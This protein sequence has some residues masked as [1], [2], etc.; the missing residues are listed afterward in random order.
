MSLHEKGRS[1]LKKRNFD[2]ALVL[3]LEAVEEYKLCR[4]ELLK[5][6]DNYA[7]LNLDI[8]WCYLQL[9]NMSQLP[10]AEDR[11]Q[12]CERSFEASYGPNL[13]RLRKVKG[14]V[15]NERSLLFRMH[16]LQGIV[17]FHQG[18]R[19]KATGLL[20]DAQRE[21]K[22]LDV[23]ADQLA[24]VVAQG[25]SER[26][27]RIAL[28]ATDGSVAAA[29]SYAQHKRE[30]RLRIEKEERERRRLRRRYGKTASG[31]AINLGFVKTM[32]GMGIGEAFAVEALRQTDNSIEEAIAVIQEN[33][34]L[35][36]AAIISAQESEDLEKKM[37]MESD[38]E[39]KA[40]AV[41]KVREK[42]EARERMEKDI[43]HLGDT[44]DHLDLALVEEAEYLAKY[45]EFL[46]N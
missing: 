16:L 21:L 43:G 13:E 38:V 14:E 3:L 23:N 42:E 27:A 1:A 40:F 8:A 25:Y 46:K 24:E 4:S 19:L 31:K 18:H 36:E 22:E 44:E 37:F 7:L 41:D 39:A 35:I 33:P 15:D 11:L 20:N 9:G 2:L 12:E 10:N 17:A 34:D 6:V 5:G 32:T 26:E 45:L 29:V 28:R 30:E